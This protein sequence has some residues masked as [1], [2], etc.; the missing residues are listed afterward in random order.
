MLQESAQSKIGVGDKEEEE[1]MSAL[2]TA[3]IGQ[4][5]RGPEG[6]QRR[7]RAIMPPMN[8]QHRSLR[9]KSPA[10]R[11]L[12]CRR[13]RRRRAGSDL[14]MEVPQTWLHQPPL[15]SVW[16]SGSNKPGKRAVRER[17]TALWAVVSFAVNCSQRLS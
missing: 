6:D 3:M 1:F 2:E 7:S 9:C 10:N 5:D 13:V 17:R 12:G 16:Q 11:F 15:P 14:G 4:E 8:C